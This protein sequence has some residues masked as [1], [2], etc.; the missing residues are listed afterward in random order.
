MYFNFDSYVNRKIIDGDVEIVDQALDE[1][2]RER[3]L[4][5]KN[6]FAMV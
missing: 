4:L 5:H 1:D 2:P 3:I 6:G